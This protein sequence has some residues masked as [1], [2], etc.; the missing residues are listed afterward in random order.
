MDTS[1]DSLV[2]PKLVTA[3]W[4]TAILWGVSAVLLGCLVLFWPGVSILVAAVLFGIYL[5]VSGILQVLSAFGV[6]E[7]AGSRAL[8]FISGAISVVLAVLAFR[9]FGEGY[10]VL[11]LAIWIGVGFVFQGASEIAVASGAPGLPGRG[12]QI[13]L[14]VIT[15]IAGVVVLA[16]PFDSIVVLTIVTGISFIVIGVSQIIKAVMLRKGLKKVAQHIESSASAG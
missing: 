13:V 2:T 5:F 1:T 7:R 9:H 8:L 15:V 16:W 12:W 4:Q 3:L 14:G 10:G 11:F 6:H